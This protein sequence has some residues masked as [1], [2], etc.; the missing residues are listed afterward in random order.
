VQGYVVGRPLPIEDYADLV[1][2]R[3]AEPKQR[4]VLVK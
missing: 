3:P 4:L 2:R 1:G